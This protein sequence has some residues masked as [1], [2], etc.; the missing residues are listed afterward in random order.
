M[1]DTAT[2]TRVTFGDRVTY[3]YGS[4]NYVGTVRGHFV[5]AGVGVDGEGNARDSWFVTADRVSAAPPYAYAPP[6]TTGNEYSW[7]DG[8]TPATGEV[9]QWV[10]SNE[11]QP[12]PDAATVDPSAHQE[13]LDTITRLRAE[14]SEQTALV[15][16]AH[17]VVRSIGEA[18]AETADRSEWC[19]EYESKVERLLGNLPARGGFASTFG[20]A[21]N[22]SHD[23]RVY[24]TGTVVVAGR[25]ADQAREA[26]NDLYVGDLD[27]YT[28]EISD[29]ER[30]D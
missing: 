3:N 22:R 11:L 9:G 19:E 6:L 1:T 30:D 13:A 16:T 17:D 23:Y 10:R 12:A 26:F 2:L 14:L 24:F 7:Q 4:G 20:D 15:T 18:L 5:P 8:Y 25:N 29:V 27:G 21:A 28:L